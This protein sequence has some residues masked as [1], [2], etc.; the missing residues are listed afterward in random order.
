M[1]RYYTKRSH[2]EQFEQIQKPHPNGMWI[3]GSELTVEELDSLVAT[4][5]LKST[6][7]Y[8]VRDRQE[9]SRMEFDHD[10]AYVF[11]RVPHLANSGRVNAL[12]MLSIVRSDLFFTISQHE[13]YSPEAIAATTLPLDTTQTVDL[14]LGIIAACVA[15]YQELIKHTE[16]SINDTGNRLKTHEVTNG[17]FIHFVIVEDNLTTFR[18]NL[19]GILSVVT[20]LIDTKKIT[21]SDDNTEALDDIAQHIK[22]L[23]VAVESYRGRVDSIRN[24]YSTIANNTLSQRMKTLTVLTVLITLPN[25]IFGMFGMNVALPFTH[26]DPWA[27]TFVVIG[28]III[29]V[30]VYLIGRKRKLF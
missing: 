21:L 30:L 2:A 12:P 24:A 8:D 29:T 25:I 9:L 13:T 20:R 7:V 17:D 27:Y 1:L 28:S 15:S 6:V 3:D 10:A 16:R 14:L 26:D 5:Q 19:E 22:Q 11:L 4:Y 18:V 23:L